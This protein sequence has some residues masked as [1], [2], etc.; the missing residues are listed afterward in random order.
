MASSPHDDVSLGKWKLP[1]GATGVVSSGISHMDKKYWNDAGGKH[2]L[3]EFWPDRFLVNPADPSSGPVR[4]DQIRPMRSRSGDGSRKPYFS[5]E[6]LDGVWI[7]YGGNSS[8]PHPRIFEARALISYLGG[9]SICP[10]RFLAKNVVFFF[11]ALLITR[12]DIEPLNDDS[13]QLDP[14]RYGL[15]AARTKYPVPVRI[16]KRIDLDVI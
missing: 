14:W 8:Y 6:G 3:S 15:G 10:G 13:F 11:C 12:F 5:T 1:R 16:R 7:P 2:P 9:P 4:S